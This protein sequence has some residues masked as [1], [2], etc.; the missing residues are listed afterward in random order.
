MRGA[1]SPAH[2]TPSSPQRRG[3]SFLFQHATALSPA[4]TSSMSAPLQYA[5]ALWKARL[6]SESSLVDWANQQILALPDP[7]DALIELSLK[8]PRKYLEL[9]AADYP[10]AEQL[11]F[12]DEFSLRAAILDNGSAEAIVDFADWLS[13]A[14]VGQ[15][16]DQAEVMFGHQINYLL[17][18]CHDMKA[19]IALV[20]ERLPAF[21]PQCRLR[22]AQLWNGAALSL[23]AVYR[24]SANG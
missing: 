8:G 6:L 22:A 18:D 23:L 9:P 20:H 15:N 4:P 1:H 13:S 19:T 3:S 17:D 21:L 7:G 11:S 16:L 10:R 14:C 12:L 24:T 2:T 5:L